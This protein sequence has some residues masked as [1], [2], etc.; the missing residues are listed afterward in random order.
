MEFVSQEKKNTF[1]EGK[2]NGFEEIHYGYLLKDLKNC[3]DNIRKTEGDEHSKSFRE[4]MIRMKNEIEE[5]IF[6]YEKRIYRG[7][8]LDKYTENLPKFNINDF[9]E[10]KLSEDETGDVESKQLESESSFP[11][12]S[13]EYGALNAYFYKE[14]SMINKDLDHN[15]GSGW[16]DIP[17]DVREH[18]HEVNKELIKNIDS[19][20]NRNKGLI[21]PTVIYTGTMNNNV[22]NIHTR[23]GEKINMK[24]YISASFHENVA[25]GHSNRNYEGYTHNIPPIY[26]KFLAPKRTKGI[27]ANGV[28]AHFSFEHE[29]LLGRG[30]SGTVVDIDYD[31]GCVT[32]LLDE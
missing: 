16:E 11:I 17:K 19:S 3:E 31:T 15:Y 8:D 4:D 2:L 28:D 1:L 24:S 30:Q 5:G 26:V 25:K 27:C 9:K 23:I 22:A 13:D 18:I 7:Y 32:V 29:Y 10:D 20:I 6:N 12:T 14:S 21:Q